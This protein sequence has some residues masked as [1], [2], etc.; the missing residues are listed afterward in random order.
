MASSGGYNAEEKFTG[1]VVHVAIDEGKSLLS[2]G[3]L[4]RGDHSRD[5]SVD[6]LGIIRKRMRDILLPLLGGKIR[7][8]L[9]NWEPSSSS[10]EAW[11]DPR[12]PLELT[13][14]GTKF[15]SF[16]SISPPFLTDFSFLLHLY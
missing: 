6:Y 10:S 8:S 2:G 16:L 3:D 15:F 7:P 13:S 12:L 11:S 1:D 14:G 9:L 5:D 4:S